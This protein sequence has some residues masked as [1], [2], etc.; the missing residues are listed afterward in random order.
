MYTV[1]GSDLQAADEPVWEGE[2]EDWV[3]EEINLTDYLSAGDAI[4]L[5]F[6]MVSDQFVNPDGFYVDDLE[7]LE[8]NSNE[9]STAT[10]IDQRQFTLQVMPN[11]SR[12]QSQFRARFPDAYQGQVQWQLTDAGGQ[13]HR[14][15]TGTS[16]SGLFQ[17]ELNTSALAAGIYFLQLN[18]SV[19][20]PVSQRIIVVE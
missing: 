2:Q 19:H 16:I 1:P 3:Q 17:A 20:Q 15:G 8:R 6:L 4:R 7:L 14:Q 12:G 5:R 11:P 10:P 13:V 9:V 18:T